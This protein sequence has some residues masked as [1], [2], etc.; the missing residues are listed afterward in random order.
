[1]VW[2]YILIGIC[3]AIIIFY[4]AKIF[5]RTCKKRKQFDNIFPDNAEEE[6]V[7]LKKEGVQIVSKKL[8]DA[9]ASCSETETNL[10]EVKA[11]ILQVKTS[12][13]KYEKK[14]QLALAEN[15]VESVSRIDSNLT[16]KRNEIKDLESQEKE[17]TKQ[18]KESKK[19]IDE[20][21]RLQNNLKYGTRYVIIDSINKYLE[22]NKDA[23]TDFNLIRDIIDRNCDAVE[24]EIQTQIPIPLY[25]G[26]MGTMLGILIG[27]AALVV[28]GSLDNL[29]STFTPP[30]GVAEGSQEY[31]AAKSAFE[32]TATSGV[33]ALFGGVALAMISSIVGIFLTI[34]G[35]LQSKNIKSRVESKKH[36]FISWL[37]AELL[38]KISSDLSSALIKLGNDLS[39]FNSSFSSN[40]ELLQGTISD[41]SKATIEQSQLL[42][43]IE[44]L[45]IARIAKANINVYENLKNC[46]QEISSLAH[47]MHEIQSN[48]RG[49]GNYMEDGINEYKN[50]HTY[51]QD[52]AGNVDLAIQKGND[53]LTKRVSEIFTKYDELLNNL[54]MHSEATTKE[55]AKK[56]E[57]QVENL[58]KAIVE[59]LSDIHQLENELKNLVSVKTSIANLEKATTE[60]NRKI[61]SLT[62]AI[63]E[64]ALTKTTGGTT[65][66][67]MQMPQLYKVLIIATVSVISVTGLFFLITKIL[68]I[69]GVIL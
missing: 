30:P 69:I 16:D 3:I 42:Q 67:S 44:K 47:D 62:N 57:A 63:K 54:Y 32:K 61:D 18:I 6:W 37:Q 10:N 9:F 34:I 45:D 48:I 55:L 11:Q 15:D 58:H 5:K 1:M 52:A 40:A 39:K 14:L 25:F 36:A 53:E 17:L 43:S 19:Q 2:H 22:K 46:T 7:V 4:Q 23:V 26:L 59:K 13:E 65:S 20:L 60:Q 31:E 28:S 64:L 49:L 35:S 50:R 29:L 68:E 51:I 12:I 41:V 21:K 24:E 56:Y 8:S 27:V 38:P 66:V 33:T